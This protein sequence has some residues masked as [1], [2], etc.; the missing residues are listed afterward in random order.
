ME[1]NFSNRLEMSL[2]L[3]DLTTLKT[4]VKVWSPFWTT[5]SEDVAGGEIGI[6]E[7][8]AISVLI[9]TTLFLFIEYQGLRYV[10]SM[11]FDDSIS[12]RK[13]FNLLKPCVGRS[14]KEI[15]DLEVPS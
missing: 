14:I 7:D 3:R 10:G 15:G 1:H 12:C 6:L 9:P 8:I 5:S 13:I 2:Q 11:F 4:G